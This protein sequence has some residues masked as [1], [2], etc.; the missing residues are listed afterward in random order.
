MK[1]KVFMNPERILQNAS[2]LS[3]SWYGLNGSRNRAIFDVL[4]CAEQHISDYSQLAKDFLS[5]RKIGS[6][7]AWLIKLG[8][9]E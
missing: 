9:L 7:V 6:S 8:V 5:I 3:G 2:T 4:F 1:A